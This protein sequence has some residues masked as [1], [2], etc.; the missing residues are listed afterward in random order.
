MQPLVLMVDFNN[1]DM[2]IWSPRQKKDMEPLEQVQRRTR[3]MVQA[4]EHPSYEDRLRE[5]GLFSLEKRRLWGELIA[6]RK[7][8]RDFLQGHVLIE[9]EVTA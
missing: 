9:Q 8:G 5:L 6:A 2:E 3:K 4:L 7:L 1:P